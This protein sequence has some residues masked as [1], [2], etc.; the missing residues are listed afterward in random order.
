MRFEA[1]RVM[2]I[3]IEEA[4]DYFAV[5]FCVNYIEGTGYKKSLMLSQT[6]NENGEN[7]ASKLP[8]ELNSS[9]LH[10]VFFWHKARAEI[11]MKTLF[12][13]G[14]KVSGMITMKLQAATE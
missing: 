11:E 13:N 14:P 2:Y 5:S 7:I 9:L 10:Y 3:N 4:N 8:L 6:V 12:T 1:S